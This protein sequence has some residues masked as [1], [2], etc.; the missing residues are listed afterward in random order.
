MVK[1]RVEGGQVKKG[2]EIK[3]QGNCI[4]TQSYLSMEETFSFSIEKSISREIRIGVRTLINKDPNSVLF[5]PFRRKY[6]E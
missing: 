3:Y 6:T 1:N 4:W 2:V 5:S